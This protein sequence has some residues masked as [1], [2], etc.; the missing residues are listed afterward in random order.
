M[1]TE[2]AMCDFYAGTFERLIQ[3]VVSRYASV[4]EVECM[5]QGGA[6]C[7]FEIQGV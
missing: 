1:H 3:A 5:A 6:A 2:R 7:R 4:V